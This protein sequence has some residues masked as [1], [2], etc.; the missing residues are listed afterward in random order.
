MKCVQSVRDCHVVKWYVCILRCLRSIILV[1][2]AK[3]RR[4]ETKGNKKVAGE[5]KRKWIKN[6][7]N[8]TKINRETWDRDARDACV[9]TDLYTQEGSRVKL[10]DPDKTCILAKANTEEPK[11][12][13]ERVRCADFPSNASFP[14]Q[15]TARLDSNHSLLVFHRQKFWIVIGT[16]HFFWH[17]LSRGMIKTDRSH[18]HK[19]SWHCN[20]MTFYSLCFQ[21][22]SIKYNKQYSTAL[23]CCW[24][25]F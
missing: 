22:V 20:V 19:L 5:I 15:G 18:H 11:R 7:S 23:Y 10:R 21:I 1:S 24:A 25:I 2:R 17:H 8:V 9:F 14:L 13:G 16:W 6:E 12:E 4:K 3:E